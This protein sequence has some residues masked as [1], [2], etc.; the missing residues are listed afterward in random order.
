MVTYPEI[1]ECLEGNHYWILV[2]KRTNFE[3]STILVVS[4]FRMLFIKR[5]YIAS[6]TKHFKQMIAFSHNIYSYFL[7]Q[8]TNQ[9]LCIIIII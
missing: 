5:S 7:V 8:E 3:T 2:Y 9:A 1:I 4:L 6:Y